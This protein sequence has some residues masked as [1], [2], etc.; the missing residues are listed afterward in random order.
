M[1]AKVVEVKT[2]RILNM[3]GTAVIGMV[4]GVQS[5]MNTV[6]MIEAG[7]QEMTNTGNRDGSDGR[8]RGQWRQGMAEM[9]NDVEWVDT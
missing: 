2:R 7:S 5:E 9:K 8:D 4:Q 6:I 3:I 1:P